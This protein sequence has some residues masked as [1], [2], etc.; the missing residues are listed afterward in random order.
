MTRLPWMLYHWHP[1]EF[2]KWKSMPPI[3]EYLLLHCSGRG[4]FGIDGN[5]VS[6]GHADR[7]LFELV[8]ARHDFSSVVEFGTWK[9]VTSLYLGVTAA[10]R[11][12]L[13][14]TFDIRD[15]RMDTVKKAWLNNMT[16]KE[17]DLLTETPN[18]EVVN[19]I[20]GDRTLLIVDNGN[21]ELETEKYGSF[22]KSGS[23]MIIHDWRTEVRP[24][25]ISPLLSTRGYECCYESFAS[26]FGS[27][28]S[29][30]IKK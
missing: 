18:Q 26:H 12:I 24:E 13:F 22:L 19:A 6:W 8:M 4:I 17:T 27:S 28:C 29:F 7:L 1:R 16:F 5:D 9:G 10:I 2:E 15:F 20:S 30:W 21:K 14:W 3:R 25:V 23:A 11:G